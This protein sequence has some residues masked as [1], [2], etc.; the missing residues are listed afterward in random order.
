[1]VPIIFVGIDLPEEFIDGRVGERKEDP[2]MSIGAVGSAAA[3]SLMLSQAA[4]RAAQAS[5]S[6]AGAE[7]SESAAEERGETAAQERAENAVQA[8][9]LG[10]SVD[11]Y[12]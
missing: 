3:R 11:T 2:E 1:M 5:T 7:A 4:G 6:K 10:G 12:A 8:Q 9:G